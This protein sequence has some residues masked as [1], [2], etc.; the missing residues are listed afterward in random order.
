MK[1]QL[2]STDRKTRERMGQFYTAVSSY[3]AE[4][5][6]PSETFVANLASEG[7]ETSRGSFER[8]VLHELDRQAREHW[9]IA[10]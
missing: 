9:E 4:I 7:I 2:V 6:E 3:A 1:F 5:S 10:D 8:G